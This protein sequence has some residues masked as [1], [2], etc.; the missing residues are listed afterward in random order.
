MAATTAAAPA[1]A[2]RAVLVLLGLLVIVSLAG[3]VGRLDR[4]ASLMFDEVYY[5]N[6]ARVILDAPRPADNPWAWHRPAIDPNVEHPPGGK[7]LLAASIRLLG[8]NP[9]GWR[10]PGALLGTAAILLLYVLARRA[11]ALPGV[12][13]LAAFAFACDDLAFVHG[14]VA[15]LDGPQVALMLAGLWAYLAGRPVLAGLG[16]VAAALVKIAGLYG[17]A[18]LVALEA[19]RWWRARP[20]PGAWRPG[21]LRP[22]LLT[23]AA[24]VVGYPLALGALDLGWGVFKNPLE[25]L[26]YVWSYGYTL[27][28]T[29]GSAAATSAPWQWLLN[30]VPMLYHHEGG[31]TVRAAMNPLV[32]YATVPALAWAVIAARRRTDDVPLVVLALFAACYLPYS[33]AA[34]AGRL[35]YIYYFLPALPAVAL[36][37]AHLASAT[38]TRLLP[39]LYAAAVLGGF[40]W[41]FPYRGGP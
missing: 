4:P 25:H 24:F 5:V 36:G 38:R 8:D 12:A 32:V 19:L 26:S 37:A 6:A 16:L 11:G 33:L 41:R 10:L 3:R 22:L 40:A 20:T 9:W 27:T 34:A 17:L 30:R 15:T 23:T 29:S 39:W 1:R 31:A 28:N 13:L 18:A 35:S 7:L 2:S 21:A 14:R